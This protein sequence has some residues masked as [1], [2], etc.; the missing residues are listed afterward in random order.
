MV[1]AHE[2]EDADWR[3]DQQMYQ[4]LRHGG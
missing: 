3:D 2:Q 1:K 4:D